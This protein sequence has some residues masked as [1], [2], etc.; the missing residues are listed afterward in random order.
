MSET[1][2]VNPASPPRESSKA[3]VVLG[4]PEQ[5]SLSGW[6]KQGREVGA[7]KKKMSKSSGY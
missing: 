7:E 5:Q 2:F 6:T 1:A 3:K 4:T